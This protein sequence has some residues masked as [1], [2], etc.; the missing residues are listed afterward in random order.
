V[1][2]RKKATLQTPWQVFITRRPVA[3]STRSAST[4]MAM[5]ARDAAAPTIARKA[6]IAGPEVTVAT[7]A[8]AKAQAT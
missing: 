4:L 7:P 1:E 8:A 2:E 3:A 5:L 6:N